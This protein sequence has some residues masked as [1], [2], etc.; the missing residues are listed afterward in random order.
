MELVAALRSGRYSQ[1]QKTLREGDAFCC[2]GV[3]CDISGVGSWDEHDVY[4]VD[5]ARA[6]HLLPIEVSEYFGLET[7]GGSFGPDEVRWREGLSPRMQ[8]Y[9]ILDL[10]VLNDEGWSFEQIADFIEDNWEH[11][12]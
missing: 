12:R 9:L 5:S 3:A 7:N 11:V 6:T 4:L 8:K 10:A 2:L 1:T